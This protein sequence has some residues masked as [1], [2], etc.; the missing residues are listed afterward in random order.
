[1]VTN[2]NAAALAAREESQPLA[3]LAEYANRYCLAIFMPLAILLWIYG[4]Q[5]FRL[6]IGP[7]GAS[8]AAPLLPILLI[9]YLFAAV[10][11]FSSSML[12]LGLGQHQRYAKGLF[13]EAAV[14]V[15][16][17]WL[18][19]P[20]WGILGVAW[21]CSVLMFL[22]RGVFT[23][24]LVARTLSIGFRHYMGTIYLTARGRRTRVRDCIPGACH[25]IAGGQLATNLICRN[26]YKRPLLCTC[27]SHL[28]GSRTSLPAVA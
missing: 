18:V 19:I 11:Q 1:V 22:N 6:W 12:L 28:P 16:A 13:A 4:D 5:F 27:V 20:R 21:T 7:A 8:Q 23:P 24:W 15:L 10:A 25:V 17:L 3:K 26:A 2:V 14:A 9:S